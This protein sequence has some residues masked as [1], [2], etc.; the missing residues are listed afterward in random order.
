[1]PINLQIKKQILTLLIE[2][3]SLELMSI[4]K[5]FQTTKVAEFMNETFGKGKTNRKTAELLYISL[6][7]INRYKT[8]L[9]LHQIVNQLTKQE[10]R[11]KL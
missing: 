4:P 9:E 5:N 11:N 7:T 3:Q 6:S 8:L 10:K 2:F 1:M